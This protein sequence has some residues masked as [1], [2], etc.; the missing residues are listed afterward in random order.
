M[1]PEMIKKQLETFFGEDKEAVQIVS[2]AIDSDIRDDV[3]ESA[4]TMKGVCLLF[5]FT[6]MAST[7]A[8][9][10]KGAPE[11]S[12]DLLNHLLA[13]FQDDIHRT[14]QILNSALLLH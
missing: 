12:M 10:E 4:H 6:A 7:L 2:K 13:Q 14:R 5:G 11:L 8:K 1:P 9:I 3:I